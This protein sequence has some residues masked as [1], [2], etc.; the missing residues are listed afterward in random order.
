MRKTLLVMLGW[1]RANYLLRV[2]EMA[3]VEYPLSS[4]DTKTYEGD[5]VVLDDKKNFPTENDEVGEHGEWIIELLC[6][7][8]M[9]SRSRTKK[10][11]VQP[12]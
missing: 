10:R 3:K 12:F 6:Y 5:S 1:R 8:G 2:Q 7:Q 4:Q 9:K 11:N